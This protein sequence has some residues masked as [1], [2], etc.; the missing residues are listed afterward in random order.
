[1][2]KLILFLF[3]LLGFLAKSQEFDEIYI[4]ETFNLTD[5][6]AV[7]IETDGDTLATNPSVR[8]AINDSTKWDNVTGGINYADGN[9]GIGTSTPLSA[10][11]LNKGTGSLS[12]GLSFTSGTGLYETSAGNLQFS[13]A[14]TPIMAIRNSKII[15]ASSG[16]FNI[17]NEVASATNPIYSF[18][19]DEG[20]GIGRAAAG[21]LSL[22]ANSIKA[23]RLT[24]D[25]V[26][27]DSTL[28]VDKEL[29]IRDT[30]IIDL[31]IEHGGGTTTGIIQIEKIEVLYTN[32]SQTTIIIL[33]SNAVVWDVG[34]E[35]VTLFDDSGTDLLNVGITATGNRYLSNIDISSVFFDTILRG[36]VISGSNIPDKMSG[37][38]NITFQYTGQNSDATQGQGFVYIHYTIF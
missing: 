25:T 33:P 36:Q 15:G 11:H 8:K 2:K 30:T 13:A 32:T 23:M 26:F 9:V 5:S 24:E 3:V 17:L 14:S 37:S 34:V 16:K 20:T 35:V 4:R 38:T 1:M 21:Q 28:K 29:Y 12:T 19:S 7:A 27:V 10:L 18:F 31:I 22:I 6:S